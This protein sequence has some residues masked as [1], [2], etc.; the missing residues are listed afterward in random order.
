MGGDAKGYVTCDGAGVTLK[1][2]G[3]DNVAMLGLMRNAWKKC[4]DGQ[5]K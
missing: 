2:G 1:L 5:R 3:D 4:Q